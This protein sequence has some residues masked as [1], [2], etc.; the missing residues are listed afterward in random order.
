VATSSTRSSVT[1]RPSA[2]VR[3][4]RLVAPV[5]ALTLLVGG[6][7]MGS[8]PASA[9]PT[10]T[11]EQVQA[12]VDAL[13]QAAADA[14]E[15]WNEART[16]QADIER[17]I[18]T[19][20][21]RIAAAKATYGKIAGAV[22]DMARAAYASGGI[23][24]SLQA[25]LADDPQSFLEQSAA[26]DQVARS[27]GTSL[28]RT[29]TARL[30]L[31]QL[32][33]QLAQQQQAADQ[34]S[35]DAATNKKAVSDKLAEA[36]ALLSSLKAEERARLEALNAARRAASAKAAAAA[37]AAARDAAAR[38]SRDQAR[39]SQ[40]PAT[41]VVR[42]ATRV[43]RPRAGRGSPWPT[44]SRRSAIATSRRPT[45]PARST[46]RDSRSPPGGTRAPPCR[47]TPTRSTAR[48]AGSA[49]VSCGQVTC[50][51]TSV[52]ARTTSRCTSAAG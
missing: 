46:A 35:A 20:K 38:A 13:E 52:A 6:L 34:A 18:G 19:L 30:L 12:E 42:A 4:A 33:A 23:E 37:A 17:K 22:D 31:A 2:R 29:Q 9:V 26:L 50:C 8:T 49:A 32:D 45:G 21:V 3:F 40:G 28:R 44:P 43:D 51:S 1:A 25:L 36:Q 47:T 15:A 41:P 27:Q 14:A 10:K 48:P 7:A 16:R 11:I 39:S 24:P 5:A